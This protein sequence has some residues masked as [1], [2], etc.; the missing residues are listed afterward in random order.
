MK[1]TY[2]VAC[3]KNN[4]ITWKYTWKHFQSSSWAQK[5]ETSDQ[6]KIVYS[7]F[8]Q[9]KEIGF[10]IVQNMMTN[11]PLIWIAMF[12]KHKI[13]FKIPVVFYQTNLVTE[14]THL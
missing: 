12:A 11:P 4:V 6:N 9:D 2:S 1:R 8:E 5:H 10:C 13:V 14:N 3:D 7:S